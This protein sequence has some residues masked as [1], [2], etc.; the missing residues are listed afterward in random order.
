MKERIRTAGECLSARF[1]D[2]TGLLNVLWSICLLFKR[3]FLMLQKDVLFDRLY[4]ITV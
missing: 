2:A 3:I 4:Y 1:L